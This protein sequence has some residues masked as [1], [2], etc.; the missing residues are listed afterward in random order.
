MSLI[1]GIVNRHNSFDGS[2]QHLLMTPFNVK[3]QVRAGAAPQRAS[4]EWLKNRIV[5]FRTYCLPSVVSQSCRDFKWLIFVDD[6]TPSVY[7]DE[8]EEM[9]GS[10]PRFILIKCSEWSSEMLR[11]SVILHSR[12]GADW[13][14]TTRLDN[15][16]GIAVDFVERLHEGIVFNKQSF[17][18]FP[19][20]VLL[21]NKMTFLYRHRSNAFL[22]F[23]EPI[24][25][26]KTVWCI[27]HEQAGEVAPV[28]QLHGRPAFLQVVHG[29]NVSN[30]TR[31]FRVDRRV[32]VLPFWSGLREVIESDTSAE[33]RLE[34]IGF[35]LRYYF[36][37]TVRDFAARTFRRW[38]RRLLMLISG[39]K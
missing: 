25:H 11:Q 34:I 33:S 6:Q 12:F 36:F 13:L 27:A 22:S 14:L 32:A 23:F 38:Q 9:L 2:V 19:D 20:G 3:R 29:G 8:I 24:S 28:L 4:V 17:L 1:Q 5:L 37:W 18:N 21:F 7:L 35:N 31:G 30:K 39:G 15:D 26:P 16:D 10:D